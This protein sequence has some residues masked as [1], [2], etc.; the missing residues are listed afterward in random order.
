MLP[1][2]DCRMKVSMAEEALKNAI[3]ACYIEVDD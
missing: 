3:T 2:S 1:V